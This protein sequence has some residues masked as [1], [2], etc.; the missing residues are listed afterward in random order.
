MCQ[1]MQ[2][3]FQVEMVQS[4]WMDAAFI[5]KKKNPSWKRS[6]RHQASRSFPTQT[7]LILDS[8][9]EEPPGRVSQ[10][11]VTGA[12]VTTQPQ[13]QVIAHWRER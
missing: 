8:L 13:T 12:S 4:V 6:H 11:T 10:V 7:P 2:S 1:R 5:L 3:S 9:T